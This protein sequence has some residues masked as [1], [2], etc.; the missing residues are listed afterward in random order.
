MNDRANSK[1]SKDCSLLYCII[2]T[3]IYIT[4]YTSEKKERDNKKKLKNAITT[5]YKVE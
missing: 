1:Y 5:D 3:N 2:V 4:Y